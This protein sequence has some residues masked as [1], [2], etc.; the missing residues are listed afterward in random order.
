M[1]RQHP[2][3]WLLLILPLFSLAQDEVLLTLDGKPFMRS[4]FERIYYKNNALQGLDN[5]TPAA[6][7]ELYINFRLKVHE[8]EKLGYDT[9][10]RF[11]SEL[12]GYRDQLAQPYLQDRALIDS[13]L[14]EAYFRTA[15]EVNASHIMAKLPVNPTPADTARAYA[16]IVDIR[17]RILEGESFETIA[18]EESDDK[19]N[20]GQLGWFSAFA[21]VFPF[22]DA[23]YRLQVGELSQPVRTRYGYHVIRLN[24]IRPS[25]GE[26][27]LAH[28]MV[29][30][31]P[32]DSREN[33]DKAREKI[34]AA[35]RLL[36]QGI[37]F[38]EVVKQY[39]ED[40]GSAR[41]GGQLRWLRSGELPPSIEEVVF[42]LQD[43]GDYTAPLQSDY[44]WHIFRL[45][46]K[47]PIPPF[48]QMKGQLEQRIMA[49]E[50]G[51]LASESFLTTLK[52]EYGLIH[53]SENISALAA[54]L[55][56]SVYTG[57][58][59]I[60]AAG[61]LIDPVF[62]I[63]RRE[64]TQH[65]LADYLLQTHV[66]RREESLSSIV[67]R[68]CNELINKI[69]LSV[70][71]DH[72][73]EKYPEFSYLMQEY[74]DGILLFNIMED[75]VWNKAIADSAGLRAFHAQHE[76]DYV[77][78]ERASVSVYTFSDSSLL[79]LTRKLARKRVGMKLGAADMISKICGSDTLACVEVTDRLYEKGDPAPEGRFE[80]KK[81]YVTVIRENQLFK[82]LA[83]NQIL[84]PAVKSFDEIRGQVTAD[85]QNF[86]D[87]QWIEVL[88]KKYPVVINEAVIQTIR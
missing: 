47:R 26:I 69:L 37:P 86:L 41:S 51:K 56:S 55:D 68:K 24:G 70:E 2:I 63:D 84:P 53:Y 39:S 5:R 22:E 29:R 46:G 14:R 27:K 50:R 64:Y 31:L 72:L 3:F 78:Q 52:R 16:R 79:E 9:S 88:R 12:A 18:R 7:L 20:G 38:T 80:W 54:R 21:M 85:Y 10:A 13:L 66:Y 60:A 11:R 28:I 42:L 48:D 23:A 67:D 33:L 87:R 75:Q 25:Q 61:D 43:S 59:S 58:W 71:K 62:E 8:A 36:Q 35:H 40:P 73:E 4:E 17:K 57:N 19:T 76:K 83:V 30:A 15:N 82:V 1:K 6:Y 34:L 77:W 45:E 32:G 65:D 81:G 74:H 49:D 44:G